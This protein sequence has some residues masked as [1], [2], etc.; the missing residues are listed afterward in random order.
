MNPLAVKP[1]SRRCRLA[2]AVV[3]GLVCAG[4]CGPGG[5][6]EDGKP[7]EEAGVLREAHQGPVTITLSVAPEEIEL[8]ER[9]SVR[10]EIIAETGVTVTPDSYERALDESEHRFDYRITAP[11]RETAVP[12]GDGRLRWSYAC[13]LEFVLPGEYELPAAG[14]SFIDERVTGDEQLG[15]EV[16]VAGLE[17]NTL[18]TEPV[19]VTVHELAGIQLSP[20]EMANIRILD[21]VELPRQWGVWWWLGP[22]LILGVIGL[23]LALILRR[24][25]RP[26]VVVPTPAHEWAQVR[27]AALVAEDLIAKGRV[28]EYYY[29]ISDIVRG[30]LER[31]F[32][33]SA[34]EMTTEEFLLAMAVDHRFGENHT[35]ELTRFLTACDLVKYARLEP[36]PAEPRRLLQAGVD[37]VERTRERAE[38]VSGPAAGSP[39]A[40][41]HAA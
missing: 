34:P 31:R 20:E 26:M 32:H 19:T 18:E 17:V 6:G 33:V 38:P 29:R 9:A 14:L 27:F 15:Q 1:R 2:A 30:Y 35:Q 8:P 11:Q 25:R 41:E 39:P 4:G 28:Q 24:A 10:V 36:E 12:T 16:T 40:K 7:H 5:A 37:F 22:V 23:A 3:A 13:E 21:P